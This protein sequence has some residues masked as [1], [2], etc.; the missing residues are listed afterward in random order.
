MSGSLDD[1]IREL[2]PLQLQG[3][4]WRVLCWALLQSDVPGELRK[5]EA[6]RELG[7]ARPSMDTIL[8]RLRSL[9]L[10]EQSRRGV[11]RILAPPDS[12]VEARKAPLALPVTTRDTHVS[13]RETHVETC[14]KLPPNPPQGDNL[15]CLSLPSIE[16]LKGWA[17]EVMEIDDV[18]ALERL[19]RDGIDRASLVLALEKA[20]HRYTRIGKLVHNPYGLLET[21]TRDTAPLE[22]L[23]YRMADYEKQLRAKREKREARRRELQTYLASRPA[24]EKPGNPQPRPKPDPSPVVET[25]EVKQ[26][27]KPRP[28]APALQALR[29]KH[30]AAAGT[31]RATSNP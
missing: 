3:G 26:P 12:P 31:D 6:M 15:S 11:W 5:A 13:T 10:V 20:Q 22:K 29:E 30:R 23:A 19:E 18:D 27:P 25:V 24:A 7:I 28:V 2:L 4:D 14:E 8:K 17:S 16:T 1:F 21:L 9:G